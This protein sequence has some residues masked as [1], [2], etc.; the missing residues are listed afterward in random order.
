MRE[1]K[2]PRRGGSAAGTV[3]NG[4]GSGSGERERDAG[5]EEAQARRIGGRG[6][7]EAEQQADV[8]GLREGGLQTCAVCVFAH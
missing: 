5:T 1:P 7:E 4:T 2:R 3:G 6:T 8:I